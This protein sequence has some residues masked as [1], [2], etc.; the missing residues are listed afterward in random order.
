MR[1]FGKVASPLFS[2]ICSLVGA[3]YGYGSDTTKLFSS[4]NMNDTTPLKLYALARASYAKALDQIPENYRQSFPI[5]ILKDKKIYLSFLYYQSTIRYKMPTI[6]F[7]PTW[8]QTVDWET[9]GVFEWKKTAS[10]EFGKD[11]KNGQIGELS[12][13]PNMTADQFREAEQDLYQ[14]L[15]VLLPAFQAWNNRTDADRKNIKRFNELFDKI[16]E[17]P[18]KPYY[19]AIGYN[20]FYWLRQ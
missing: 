7:S 2:I 12:L 5:P 19:E 10:D 15:E 3:S 9:G 20:W 16:S 6:V 1:L 14:V 8:M 4:K 18:L 11:S 17:P 13:P